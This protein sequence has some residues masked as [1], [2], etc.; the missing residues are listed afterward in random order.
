ML[1]MP[2][3]YVTDPDRSSAFYRALGLDLARRARPGSWLELQPAG[4]LLGLH[5]SGADGTGRVELCLV[6]EAPLERVRDRLLGSGCPPER[7]GDIVD[8]EFGRS[9]EVVDPD[10]VRVRVDEHDH[11][12]YT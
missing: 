4:G 7:V 3:L 1:V 11:E 6:A 10:G 9:M 5:K 2:I 12:L 8:Q